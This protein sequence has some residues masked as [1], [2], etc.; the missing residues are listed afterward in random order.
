MRDVSCWRTGY[1]GRGACA[2]SSTV[3]WAA[4]L[5]VWA[6][7]L[8]QV[9]LIDSAPNECSR[10][11]KIRAQV[12]LIPHAQHLGVELNGLWHILNEHASVLH[13]SILDI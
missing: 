2:T 10:I 11:W 13:L 9:N 12:A 5:R 4:F 8:H 6:R 7:Q 3:F 1:C